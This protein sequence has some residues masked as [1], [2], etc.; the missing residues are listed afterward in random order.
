MP[1]PILSFQLWSSRKDPSLRHQ[2]QVLKEAGY[3]DA[4]PHHAQYADPQGLRALLDEFGLT[5]KSAHINYDMI[6]IDFHKTV[7][8]MRAIGAEL[9][10]VPQLPDSLRPKDRAEWEAAGREMR[11][12]NKRLR[13]EGLRF[14]WHNHH[15]EMTPLPDGSSRSNT[16]SVTSLI[17]KS[18]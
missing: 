12:Y 15:H 13:D 4:Q 5:A 18:T 11:E 10:I 14:A 8:A 9:V 16:F 6:N 7:W 3:E 17:G 2:L 1:S